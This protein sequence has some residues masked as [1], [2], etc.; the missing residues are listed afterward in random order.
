M[1]T[2]DML[3]APCR[4]ACRSAAM[5][6]IGAARTFSEQSAGRA[7]AGPG[8]AA[9]CRPRAKK[10]GPWGRP[11]AGAARLR[12]TP[13]CTS[14]GRR[15]AGR[16]RLRGRALL[17]LGLPFLHLGDA[18]LHLVVTRLDPFGHLLALA[19]VQGIPGGQ[20]LALNLAGLLAELLAA[21]IGAGHER[22]G[23]KLAI[24]QL[25]LEQVVT[26]GAGLA[27]GFAQRI[28]GLPG[29]IKSSLLAG[30]ELQRFNLLLGKRA[31]TGDHESILVHAE[32][33]MAM[34]TAA[35]VALVMARAVG[36]G[37]R[38]RRSG[39]ACGGHGQ[40]KGGKRRTDRDAGHKGLLEVERETI[41][42]PGRFHAG[43]WQPARYFSWLRPP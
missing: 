42:R 37:R 15:R 27:H 41:V 23:V 9:G 22:P 1:P 39:E 30:V 28:L 10:S 40:A 12:S 32:M 8:H 4:Q 25:A 21:F 29:G 31:D 24:S 5:H 35:M 13:A 7:C 33:V 18:L 11:P 26:L 2:P 3:H 6:R 14:V 38:E 34:F 43:Y 17:P 20:P 19:I 16:S 36:I